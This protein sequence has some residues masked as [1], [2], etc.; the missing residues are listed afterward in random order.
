MSK[1]K[2]AIQN[3]AEAINTSVQTVA[4][5]IETSTSNQ[6]ALIVANQKIEDLQKQYEDND[7][8]LAA[9]LSPL[10]ETLKDLNVKALAA[11]PANSSGE[12]P[13]S[14]TPVETPPSVEVPAESPTEVPTEISAPSESPE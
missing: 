3:L 2:Q 8:E 14:I 6:Q 4:T 12:L 11:I 5:L 13:P 1:L 10:F 9:T 7:A